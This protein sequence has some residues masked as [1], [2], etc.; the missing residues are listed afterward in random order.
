MQTLGL[1]IIYNKQTGK[2]LNG[3]L[4]ER[5]DVGLTPELASEL[6]PFIENIGVLDLPYGDETLKDVSEFHIENGQ[7]VIDKKVIPQPTPEE[8]RIQ[9]LENELLLASGVI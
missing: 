7:I 2:V 5:F 6:R 8:L 1:R 4:G 9:E 3:T